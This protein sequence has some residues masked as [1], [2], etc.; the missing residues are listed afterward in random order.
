MKVNNI[1]I[2]VFSYETEDYDKII[3]ALNS[4]LKDFLDYIN[5]SKESVNGHYGDKITLIRYE[6]KGKVC[7]K[8]F[9][10]LISNFDQT[11]LLYFISTIDDRIEKS[12]IHIRIDK[13]R[14]LLDH[15]LY[16]KDSDDVIKI[17]ISSAGGEKI[18]KKELN[19]LVNRNLHKES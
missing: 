17:V 4:F 15:K 3:D 18:V 7:E 19:E 2:M 8:L 16:L 10:Y 6:I 5:I 14:F 12:K 1:S 9:T 11:D 13:Q